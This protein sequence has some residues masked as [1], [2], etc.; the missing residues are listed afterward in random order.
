[1]ANGVIHRCTKECPYN[2]KCFVCKTETEVSGN[3]VVLHKCA[4][5]QLSCRYQR[6][7]RQDQSALAWQFE[8]APPAKRAVALLMLY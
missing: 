3:V 4:D 8:S 6:A 1:M 5:Y 7:D 2:K